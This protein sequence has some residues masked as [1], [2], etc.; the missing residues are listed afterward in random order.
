MGLYEWIGLVLVAASVLLVL[1]YRIK[2]RRERE[3]PTLRHALFASH[4]GHRVLFNGDAVPSRLA[5]H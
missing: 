2:V 4:L 3:R 1:G 5:R